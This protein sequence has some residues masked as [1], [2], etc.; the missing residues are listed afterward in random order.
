M[1]T[2]IGILYHD[3]IVLA[4]DSLVLNEHGEITREDAQKLFQLGGSSGLVISGNTPYDPCDIDN[5]I[6]V[7][8]KRA[9]ERLKASP[10]AYLAGVVRS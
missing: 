5:L 10:L 7:P 9:A 3:G 4:A 1:T 2:G 6:E 8:V